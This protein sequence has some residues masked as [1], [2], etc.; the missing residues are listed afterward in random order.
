MSYSYSIWP[1]YIIGCN[2]LQQL[3]VPTFLVNLA[4]SSNKPHPTVQDSW[5]FHESHQLL[6]PNDGL[7][8]L[9]NLCMGQNTQ[10]NTWSNTK[11]T[12]D[13]SLSQEENTFP[14]VRAFPPVLGWILTTWRCRVCVCV[15]VCVF[16]TKRSHH[17]FF[18]GWWL[19]LSYIMRNMTSICLRWLYYTLYIYTV[20]NMWTDT[21]TYKIQLQ[22]SSHCSS[23]LELT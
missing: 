8:G 2:S 17:D 11:Y 23:I 22:H 14:S 7:H 5:P 6:T 16:P 1:I 20:Y 4:N 13:N 19:H 15:C 12:L 3:L 21:H 9:H 18:D 10:N